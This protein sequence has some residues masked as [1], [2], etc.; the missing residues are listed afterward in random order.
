VACRGVVVSRESG[1]KTGS[2]KIV[3]G[4]GGEVSFVRLNGM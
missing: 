3:G 2:T 1:E 4:G